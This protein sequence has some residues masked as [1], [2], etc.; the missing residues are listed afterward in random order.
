MHKLYYYDGKK[1]KGEISL[2][3]TLCKKLNP[4][5]AE[6][7]PFAFEIS[8]IRSE[9]SDNYVKLVLAASAEIEAMTW[10]EEISQASVVSVFN[11]VPTDT[12][13]KEGNVR[14][15]NLSP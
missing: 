15:S 6:G 13:I 14:T 9:K 1:L 8:N 4:N 11:D 3:G 5:E 2:I 12:H 10:I 7:N